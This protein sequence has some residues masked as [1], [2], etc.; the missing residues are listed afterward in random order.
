VEAV[1]VVPWA[2][3]SLLRC[4]SAS[5]LPN[6]RLPWWGPNGLRSPL[7]APIALARRMEA[8]GVTTIP[9][10]AKPAVRRVLLTGGIVTSFVPGRGQFI[11][12]A[13]QPRRPLA[14]GRRGWLRRP[15][16]VVSALCMAGRGRQLGAPSTRRGRRRG[17]RG[18]GAE[19]SRRSQKVQG[20]IQTVKFRSSGI[21]SGIH[22][23]ASGQQGVSCSFRCRALR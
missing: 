20:G 23:P 9:V 1:V 21:R 10:P 3:P 14:D 19:V 8:M 11:E 4:P 15:P 18:E 12:R 22:V 7:G 13:G 5:L 6:A 2:V 17:R 16:G